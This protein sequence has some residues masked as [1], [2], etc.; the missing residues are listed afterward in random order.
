[1][2]AISRN[3]QEAI[4]PWQM[5]W[6]I[7]PK[8]EQQNLWVLFVFLLL[9]AFAV[10]YLKYTDRVVV[11]QLQLYQQQI[12]DLKLEQSQLFLEFGTWIDPARIQ[13]IAQAE[14]N[15]QFLREHHSVLVQ[16]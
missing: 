1:M 5:T 6:A 16:Q 3:I 15:M 10:I 9:S 4:W 14:C 13:Q 2:N 12:D 8:I 11:S 7:S